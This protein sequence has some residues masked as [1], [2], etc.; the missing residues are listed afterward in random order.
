MFLQFDPDA[1]RFHNYLL[2][3][4]GG[5]VLQASNEKG[6]EGKMHKGR[7]H[8]KCKNHNKGMILHCLYGKVKMF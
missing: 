4:A 3:L 5:G 6:G 7:Y 2:G 8:H 1:V